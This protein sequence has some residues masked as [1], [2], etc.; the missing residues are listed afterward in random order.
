MTLTVIFKVIGIG[1]NHIELI[2]GR[3]IKG[4]FAQDFGLEH[5]IF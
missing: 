4:K 1:Y 3:V 5:I 2:W